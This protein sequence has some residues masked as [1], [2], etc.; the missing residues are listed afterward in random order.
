[1][2]LTVEPVSTQALND[3]LDLEDLDALYVSSGLSWRE[4][5]HQARVELKSFV[6]DGGGLV[7]RGQVGADLNE[8]LGLLDVTPVTGR[9]DANGVVRVD[10]D[11][12]SPVAGAAPPHTFVYSPLW[13]TDLGREVRADQR[14]SAEPVVSGHWRPDPDGRGG[15]DSAAGQA[16][17]VSGESAGGSRVV[18]LGSEPLFRAHPKGQYALVARSLLWAGTTS[19]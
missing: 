3:G 10:N 18:L 16:V 6:R 14:F 9:S 15:P 12:A 4:L 5:D 19:P 2:G 7:G 13:F 17:V 1:M 11:T 8:A